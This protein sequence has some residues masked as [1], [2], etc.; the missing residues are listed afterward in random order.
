MYGIKRSLCLSVILGL[1]SGGASSGQAQD[2]VA[3]ADNAFGLKLLPAVYGQADG[4]NIFIS[5]LSIALALGMAY[6]GAAG[7][8][9]EA[10]REALELG[11]LSLDEA[12]EGYRA[13]L[14]R[15]TK[16]DPRVE[17][18]PANS[19]WYRQGLD[20]KQGFLETGRRYF[21]AEIAALDF[22]SPD[23]APT[24]NRWVAEATKGL[25]DQIVESPLE[26]DVVMYL[27]NAIYFKG[28]WTTQFVPELTR[29][30]GF[31]L[32]DGG[33]VD[34]PMMQYPHSARVGYFRGAGVEA[35]DLSY[36]DGA[37]SLTI[38]MPEEAGLIGGLVG[39]LTPSRWQGIV[40]GLERSSMNVVMPK[41]KLEY[42]LEMKDVLSSLGMGVAFAP[43][44][45]DFSGIY[46][47]RPPVYISKVKHKTFVDVDEVGTEAAAVTGV[48]IMPTSMPPTVTVDRPFVFAI[49]EQASGTILFVGVMMNPAV[50]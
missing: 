47:G 42:E 7:A 18:L 35:V 39:S 45:A 22:E 37:F 5:P 20:V 50:P 6:N 33:R 32:A 10:M 9:A 8:T 2:D 29:S 12:N 46:D 28:E 13:L 23:A 31:N 43:S 1:L 34:V 49:R 36:G 15:L 40:D 3:R 27:I 48:T 19:I 11:D 41:F 24:I 44:E 16:L 30:H 21:E 14:E 17:F 4:E 38:V 25:I 26:P